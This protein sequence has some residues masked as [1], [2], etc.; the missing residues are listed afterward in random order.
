MLKVRISIL[1]G[2]QMCVGYTVAFLINQVGT[3]IF[4]GHFAA[5]FVPGLIAILI[6][7]CVVIAISRKIRAHFDEKYSLHANAAASVA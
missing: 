5:G 7:I 2:L 4:E 3:L 1:M 6:M